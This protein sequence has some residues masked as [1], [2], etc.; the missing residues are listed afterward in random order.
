[1][2]IGTK[3]T[4]P[5]VIKNADA[6]YSGISIDLWRIIADSLHL[7]YTLVERDLAGLMDG[8]DDGTLDAAV[9]AVTITA[10]RE[11]TADFS[12]PFY[13]TGLSIAVSPGARRGW[14]GVLERFLTVRFFQIVILLVLVLLTVGVIVWLLERRRNPE[15]FGGNSVQGIGSGFWWSAVTMTTVGYGDKAPRTFAGRLVGLVWMFAGIILVSSFTAGITSVLTVS[16]LESRI[17][18]IEDLP[19]ASVATVAGSTSE[20]FLAANHITARTFPTPREAIGALADGTVDAV[21]YD[22]P[23][24]R[25]LANTRHRGKVIV[26]PERLERQDYGIGLPSGSKLREPINRVL[27][28]V[29]RG[30]EWRAL[31]NGYLGD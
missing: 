2:T 19:H 29:T 23:I 24:L 22:A 5:F 20:T 8:L 9:A 27:L 1:M 3:A 21:V 6:S 17:R 18:G 15:Q 30:Q 31:V 25:Y 10:E 11:L 16:Q 14:L 4:P 26:L 7:E 13:S 12:H 28:A